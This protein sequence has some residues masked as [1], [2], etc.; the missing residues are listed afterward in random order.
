MVNENNSDLTE[1][2]L[3]YLIK[4]KSVSIKCLHFHVKISFIVC[5]FLN[6]C[7]CIY[8]SLTLYQTIHWPHCLATGFG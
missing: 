7:K 4:L 3:Q 6:I 1:T 8:L 2:E 5:K